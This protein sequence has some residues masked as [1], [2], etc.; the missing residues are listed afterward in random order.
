MEAPIRAFALFPHDLPSFR[1]TLN[2]SF[3]VAAAAFGF[4]ATAAHAATETWVGNSSADWNLAGNW[5]PSALPASGGSL[6]FGTAGSSGVT[7][8]DT[9]T[10]AAFNVGGI[11]F[12]AGASAFT[13]GGNAF[14]LTGNITNNSAALETLNQ[15]IT[16]SGTNTITSKTGG[17]NVTLGGDVE[18][19]GGLDDGGYGGTVTLE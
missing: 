6:V 15:A 7:L 11:T 9:L 17:G 12:N 10:S 13:M 4:M 18:R 3:L 14:T 19:R 1:R 16:L 8:T 5:S 2:K